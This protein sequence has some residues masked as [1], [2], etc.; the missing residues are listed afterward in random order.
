M[1]LLKPTE[2]QIVFASKLIVQIFSS[3]KNLDLRRIPQ[4]I[5]VPS[6]E[7]LIHVEVST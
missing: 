2:A 1:V 4:S 7:E 5:S 6:Y 3:E